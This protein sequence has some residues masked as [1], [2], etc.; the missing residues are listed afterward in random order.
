[1]RHRDQQ[2][3]DPIQLRGV[4][5]ANLRILAARYPSVASLCRELGINRTQFNRYL[6][7]ESFPRPDVLHRICEFFG[8]DARILLE[9]V[10]E[11]K[12]KA[13]GFFAHPVIDDFLKKTSDPISQ[14]EFP[15]GFYRYSRQSF[16][17]DS[18]FAHGLIFVF[19]EDG[20]TFMR[21]YEAKNAMSIQGLS[22][23][24]YEREFRG[25][26]IK[27]ENGFSLMAARRG[28][29]TCSISFLTQ[30]ASFNNN[31][32]EG[33]ATRTA[34]ESMSERRVTRLVFEH[35]KN[36]LGAA[37]AIARKAGLLPLEELPP[38]HARLLRPSQPFR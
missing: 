17:D 23:S 30:L 4:F 3:A 13:K 15:D 19:R 33:Y 24:P 22:A 1:M 25:A 35:I 11:A 7:G 26:V 34:A 12:S 28:A 32:W 27:Q 10:D 5:G 31:Y 37:L 2:P 36:D 29:T 18:L 14:S 38:Y 9:P 16:V 20:L 8:V 21:G 6:G